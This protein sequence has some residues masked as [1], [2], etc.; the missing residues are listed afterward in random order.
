MTLPPLLYDNYKTY[1]YDL[2]Q[3]DNLANI[4]KC[5]TDSGSTSR[6]IF[7]YPLT[8]ICAMTL[9]MALI[10]YNYGIEDRKSLNPKLHIFLESEWQFQFSQ[11]IEATWG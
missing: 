10:A 2:S 5:L 7:K 6:V 3:M 4:Y 11:F 1:Y 9:A 8:N